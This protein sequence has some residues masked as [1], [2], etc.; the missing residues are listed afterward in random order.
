MHSVD[1][2]FSTIGDLIGF[3]S[4]LVIHRETWDAI[5]KEEPIHLYFKLY[6]Q[7]YIIG[8]ALQRKPLWLVFNHSC[9]GYRSDNDQF[10][11]KLGWYERLLADVEAY[12]AISVDFFNENSKTTREFESKIFNAHVRGRLLNGKV[13]GVISGSQ[14]KVIK[15]LYKHYFWLPAFWLFVL[16]ILLI[17]RI[18]IVNLRKFYKTYIPFSGAQRAK[19]LNS[20]SK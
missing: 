11:K 10:I 15:L 6:V 12:H 20:D 7:A 9:I 1:E 16:P 18:V 19:K 14:I 8:K 5:C 2:V 13:Q 17:P 3:M 4:T